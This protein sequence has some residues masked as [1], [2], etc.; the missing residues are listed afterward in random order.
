MRCCFVWAAAVTSWILDRMFCE[1]W[2]AYNLPYLHGVWHILIA[3][4]SYTVC[5]LFAYFD[6]I[7][8]Y[9][10]LRPVIKFWP[11]DLE[12]GIPYIE[13]KNAV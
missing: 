1:T 8:E 13:L 5:V 3:I 12:H 6:A 11:N 9:E 4:A 2:S 7:H 10:D